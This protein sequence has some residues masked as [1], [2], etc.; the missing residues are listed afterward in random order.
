MSRYAEAN[1]DQK[2]QRLKDKRDLDI[3]LKHVFRTA[4]A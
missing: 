3:C 4:R 1:N 2:E